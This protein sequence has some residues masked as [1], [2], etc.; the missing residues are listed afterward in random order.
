MN[1]RPNTLNECLLGE[2]CKTLWNVGSRYGHKKN[3]NVVIG[4]SQIASCHGSVPVG[5]TS[6]GKKDI[7]TK[8]EKTHKKAASI[9][10]HFVGRNARQPLIPR[11]QNG[12]HIEMPIATSLKYT[13]ASI[14]MKNA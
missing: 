14:A 4:R 13:F 12:S 3:P 11:I 5:T 9:G 2:H 8:I 7:P 6:S 10:Q 1:A